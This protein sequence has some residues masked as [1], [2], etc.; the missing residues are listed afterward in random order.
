MRARVGL[1]DYPRTAP[2]VGLT[3]S[4]PLYVPAVGVMHAGGSRYLGIPCLYRGDFDPG[5][6]DLL[7]VIDQ[8]WG[9]LTAE[10]SVL[11]APTDAPNADA[12]EWFVNHRES[13]S[14]PLQPPLVHPFRGRGGGER[15]AA[16][17]GEAKGFQLE[18]V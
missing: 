14:L 6:M 13:L 2:A 9:G 17:C 7:F 5:H 15:P 4:V 12:A 18:E 11:N 3:M 8:L 1:E 16:G 10:P